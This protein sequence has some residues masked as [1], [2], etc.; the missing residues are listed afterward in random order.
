MDRHFLNESMI[1]S[2]FREKNFWLMNT[3]ALALEDFQD[4]APK[5]NRR[6]PGMILVSFDL[7]A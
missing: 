5:K 3:S 2:P 6:Y 4:V 1:R 7:E